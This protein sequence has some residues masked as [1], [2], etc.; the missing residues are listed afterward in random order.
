MKKIK[1]VLITRPCDQAKLLAEKLKQLNLQ[2]IM[3]PAIEIKPV[4][5]NAQIDLNKFHSLIFVSPAAIIN[6]H[7]H[8]RKIP[9]HLRIF[10]MGE[11]S[12]KVIEQLGWPKAIYPLSH[13]SRENLLKLPELQQLSHQAVLI[14]EGKNGNP[15]LKT[16]LESRGATVSSLIVYERTLPQPKKLPELDT[17]DI[18]ICTS[19]EG[20][21]NLV[22]LLGSDIK[23][24]PLLLSSQKL[25]ALA[26]TLDFTG[27]IFLA[28]NAGDN[29]LIK[30]LP[31]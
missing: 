22:A 29:A 28:E 14:I 16:I 10:T 21:K 13:F 30:A 2:P 31:I 20:L 7:S 17:I 9:S 6:F 18:A 3:F 11:D 27:R 4:N 12:A 15:E 26:K 23:T 5:F 24:K 25:V 19:Q 1:T 8:I